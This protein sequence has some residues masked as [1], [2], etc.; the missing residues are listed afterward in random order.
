MEFTSMCAIVIPVYKEIPSESE[1]LAL[2]QAFKTLNIFH[3]YLVCSEDLNL[4]HY[5][6][7]AKKHKINLH[8]KHFQKKYFNNIQGYNKLMLSLNFYSN[9]IQYKFILIYQ[10]DAWVFKNDLNYW[11]EKDYDYIGAPWLYL[12]NE[13]SIVFNG[14]GNGGLSLRKVKS[15]IRVLKS[16][17]F[18]NKIGYLYHL[19]REQLKYNAFFKVLIDNVIYNNTYHRFNRFSENEDKF[20][21]IIANRNFKWFKVADEKVACGFSVEMFP[22]YLIKTEKNIPF[23]CHAWEKYGPEFWKKHI[24]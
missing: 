9:F 7:I 12:N 2:E 1:N 5:K 10:L 6:I 14:V 18:I 22:S 8:I 4:S 3:F 11:C 15:H 17:S 13:K 24:H 16:F 21:G 20:W 19:I 23:G